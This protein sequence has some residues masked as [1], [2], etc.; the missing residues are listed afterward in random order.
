MTLKS[1][2]TERKPG[3][4]ETKKGIS[5]RVSSVL[6]ATEVTRGNNREQAIEFAPRKSLLSLTNAVSKEQ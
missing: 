6:G 3:E 4:W 1:S 5:K 2:K